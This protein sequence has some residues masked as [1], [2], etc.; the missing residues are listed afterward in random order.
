MN[1]DIPYSWGKAIKSLTPQR[2]IITPPLDICL[3]FN[4][5]PTILTYVN[6]TR[7]RLNVMDDVV[8][9]GTFRKK[10]EPEV[11][12]RQQSTARKKSPLLRCTQKREQPPAR[13]KKKAPHARAR[14]PTTLHEAPIPTE[15]VN[16]LVKVG[17]ARAGIH[18]GQDV[19]AFFNP[20]CRLFHKV[21]FE[22]YQARNS[23]VPGNVNYSKHLRNLSQRR[24]RQMVLKVLRRNISTLDVGEA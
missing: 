2:S 13:I 17:H 8:Y 14:K 4:I 7:A 18:E 24:I 9:L 5:R 1:G 21:G 11:S 20:H 12:A 22:T 15:F 10:H 6:Y 23:I 3:L 19:Y 16:R